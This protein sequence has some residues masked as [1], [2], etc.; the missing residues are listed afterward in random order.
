LRHGLN[1]LSAGAATEGGGIANVVLGEGQGIY[2]LSTDA[3]SLSLRHRH[4]YYL[5]VG[6]TADETQLGTANALL[7]AGYKDPNTSIQVQVGAF[8]NFPFFDYH[9][10]DIVHLSIPDEIDTDYRVLAITIA[11]GQDRCDLRVTLELNSLQAEYLARLQ[12]SFASNLQNIPPSAGAASGLASSQT[13]TNVAAD[14]SNLLPGAIKQRHISIGLGADQ[15]DAGDIPITDVGG[16]FGG[17]VVEMA[18]QETLLSSGAKAGATGQPQFFGMG[19][20]AGGSTQYAGA[21]SYGIYVGGSLF[22]RKSVFVPATSMLPNPDAPPTAKTYYANL[23]TWA[24]QQVDYYSPAYER[25]HFQV[26]LPHDWKEGTRIYPYARWLGTTDGS[27]LNTVAWDIEYALT[28]A[29]GVF[30]WNDGMRIGGTVAAATAGTIRTY[31]PFGETPETRIHALENYASPAGTTGPWG[32][33]GGIAATG[34]HIRANIAGAIARV[35]QAG[36]MQYPHDAFL[37]GI[38]IVYEVDYV[39]GSKG[40]EDKDTWAW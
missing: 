24:F 9:V 15:L 26:E 40:I 10:G 2:A 4:E 30:E 14:G 8:P 20:Y 25:L 28:D 29:G 31:R 22:P 32:T 33:A 5:Q 23:T 13:G 16:Y 35:E 12:R 17:T 3:A 27:D 38:E 36:D 37:L 11:E 1:I 39:A 7:L 6:N 18:L 19:V 21:D 34:R